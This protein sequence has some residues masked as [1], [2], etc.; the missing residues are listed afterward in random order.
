VLKA[1]HIAYE[2]GIAIPILLGK[3]EIILELMKEINFDG[4]VEIIDPKLDDEKE[5]KDKFAQAY[6]SSRKRNGV[7]Y[8]NARKLMRERNYFA[9]MM[10]NEGEADALVSGYSRAYPAVA[11]PMIELIGKDKGVHRVAATN[12]MIT[13]RGPMFFSDTAFNI[14]PSEQE[15]VQIAHMTHNVMK[16]FGL[17]PHLAMLSYANFGS[18]DSKSPNKVAHAVDYLHK[19]YPEIIIDGEIQA[20]FALS[21]TMRDEK[22]PFTKLHNKKVN[23]LI[24]P[25]LNS[26]NISYKLVKQL[27]NIESI[28]PIV[29][30][31]KK[32]V[33][34]LQL[35][36]SVDEIV[37]MVCV[38]VVDAQEN[39]KKQ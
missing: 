19:H 7:T 10:V 32:P 4:E 33:H 20:D 14:N 27:N 8:I 28:G 17:K 1:A 37:N 16:I 15:L 30:G 38:A 12:I 34:I 29:M 5:R 18:A 26:A 9:A 23:G 36:S 3:K 24:F 31:L 21:R 39:S 6:W 25:N 2:E 22:F 13:D 35:G 11:K